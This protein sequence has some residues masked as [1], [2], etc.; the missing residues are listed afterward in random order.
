MRIRRCSTVFI[1]PRERLDFDFSAVLA[2]GTGLGSKLEWVALAPHL[3]AEV[4]LDDDEMRV[5]G[6]LSPEHWRERVEL[7]REHAP[8]V[9]A[10]LLDKGLAVAEGALAE[11]EAGGGAR[12]RDEGLRATFWRGLAAAQH[13]FSRWQG[14]DTHEEEV[15]FAQETE[16]AFVDLLGPPPP[17]AGERCAPEQR[18]SLP[19]AGRG[20]LDDLLDRRVTCRNFDP[21]R[22]VA[23]TD[24]AAV[25]QRVFGA[26]GSAEV[27]GVPVLKKSCPSAGGLHPTEAYLLVQHVEGVAPGLY[28]YHA[29]EHALEPVRVFS[30]EQAAAFAQ[31]LIAGQ[32][33][34]FDAHVFVV[35]VSRYRRLFWKY[36]NHAKSYRATILD[37]GHLSQTMYLAATELGLGAFITAAVNEI[38]IEQA[39][40]LDP[41]QEGI[42]AVGGFGLRGAT[43][44]ELEL[45]PAGA[46][47][48]EGTGG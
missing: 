11:G 10:S 30:A 14:I 42:A 8:A 6:R 19:R 38:D 48:P 44:V 23:L 25:L 27:S 21:A 32:R 29:T 45:D 28:H 37:A 22:Q 26:R 43:C 40:G 16:S 1:E 2:G 33:H 46:V 24:F 17:P 5:L 34:F 3:D 41:M 7:E 31:R 20:P 39:L 12:S 18:H 35:M 47:W 13:R 9:L 15:Q 36:R 4:R